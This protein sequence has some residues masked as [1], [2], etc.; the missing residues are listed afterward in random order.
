LSLGQ[1]FV[2]A[3]TVVIGIAGLFLAAVQEGGAASTIGLVIFVAAVV[4]GFAFIKRHFD[5]VDAGR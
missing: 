3:L 1:L 4:Y 2:L 5:R